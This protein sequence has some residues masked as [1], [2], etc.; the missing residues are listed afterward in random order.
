[1][2]RHLKWI[3]PAALLAAGAVAA[4]SLLWPTDVPDELTRPDLDPAA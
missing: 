3:V 4:G 1:M 2:T